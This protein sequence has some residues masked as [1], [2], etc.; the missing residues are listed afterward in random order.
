MEIAMTGTDRTRLKL[1]EQEI[2]ACIGQRG[3]ANGRTDALIGLIKQLLWFEL[4]VG[5][6][7]SIMFPYLLVHAFG[8][9]FGQSFAQN[10]GHHL[11][12]V[13]VFEVVFNACI[14]RGRKCAHLIFYVTG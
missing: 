4:L 3:V 5:R 11:L 8:R 12:V 9:C 14:Y 7:T 13:V 2:D 10:L 1:V 6:I